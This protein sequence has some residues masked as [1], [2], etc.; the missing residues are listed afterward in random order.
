M[1]KRVIFNSKLLPYLLISPQILISSVFFFWPAIL[2][3]WQSFLKEDAFG[4]STEFIWFQNY[5][6]IFFD[7]NYL[8]SIFVTII[9][10]FFVT[11][12]CLT[13][14]LILAGLVY[15]VNFGKIIYQTLIICPYAVAPAIAGVLWFFL[16]NPSIGFISNILQKINILWDPNLNEN[17]ALILIIVAASW[18]QI[19]YNFLFYLA[20]LQ[21]IPKSLLEAAAIDGASSFRKFIDIIIP[22][23]SPT[24]FFLLIMNL[25][26]TFFDTFGIIFTTTQG[27]PGYSTTNLVYKVYVDGIINLN[28]GSSAAQSV[29]LMIFVSLITLIH[30][31]FV[32]KKVHY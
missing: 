23:I 8:S 6:D 3:I 9:F 25:I 11:L 14:S 30:F 1:Q 13:V 28:L 21:S 7:N 4:L 18:K 15:K 5:L 22:I 20:S 12:T 17:H 10:S 27:G 26:Y 31:K 24:T 19:S 32:E 2:A 29:I 16:F